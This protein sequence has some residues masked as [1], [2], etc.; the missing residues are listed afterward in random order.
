MLLHDNSNKKYAKRIC[1]CV[2][3]IYP[4]GAANR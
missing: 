4:V 2:A 3:Y 1:M